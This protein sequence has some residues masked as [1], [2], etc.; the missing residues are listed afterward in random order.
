MVPGPPCY[1]Q[2]D[3]WAKVGLQGTL[4]RLAD[5]DGRPMDWDRADRD[6]LKYPMAEAVVGLLS[7]CFDRDKPVRSVY[8]R[9]RLVN[10]TLEFFVFLTSKVR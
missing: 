10:H 3:I 2:K 4:R 7:A 6:T 9:E 5:E 8:G 1:Q